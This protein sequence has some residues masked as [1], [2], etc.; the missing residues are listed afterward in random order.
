MYLWYPFLTRISLD[1]LEYRQALVAALLWYWSTVV[2]HTVEV[3]CWA[4]SCYTA[5]GPVAPP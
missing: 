3:V 1:V 5:T 2:M 4:N